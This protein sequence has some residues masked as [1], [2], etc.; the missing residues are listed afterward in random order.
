MFVKC[1]ETFWS[2]SPQAGFPPQLRAE[3]S[4]SI[5]LA[6]LPIDFAIRELAL[7]GISLDE[8]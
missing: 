4:L 5:I 1:I 3:V 8:P 6:E 7:V 2:D